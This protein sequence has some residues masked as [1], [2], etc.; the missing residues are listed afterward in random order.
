MTTCC[1][2][3]WMHLSEVVKTVVVLDIYDREPLSVVSSA[4][5]ENS[6]FY[7]SVMTQCST[8]HEYGCSILLCSNAVEE[9]SFFSPLSPQS[10]L[11]RSTPPPPFPPPPQ[12][13]S[14]AVKTFLQRQGVVTSL[15]IISPQKKTPA[16]DLGPGEM[17]RKPEVKSWIRHEMSPCVHCKRPHPLLPECWLAALNYCQPTTA[18]RHQTV[19]GHTVTGSIHRRGRNQWN[20]MWKTSGFICSM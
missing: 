15:T 13:E 2:G 18:D 10:V 4:F 3:Q 12:F 9:I 20:W 1:S 11:W 7:P 17:C 6:D 16:L 19:L 8:V 14:L 5:M